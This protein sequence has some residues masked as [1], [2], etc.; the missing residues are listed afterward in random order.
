[1]T[2]ALTRHVAHRWLGSSH[3]SLSETVGHRKDSFISFPAVGDV[4]SHCLSA[5]HQAIMQPNHPPAQIL[6]LQ[7]CGSHQTPP[8][9][10]PDVL[11]VGVRPVEGSQKDE[12]R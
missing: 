7:G 1:M 2:C 11:D 10:D 4:S 6:T 3:E 8:F 5:A 9:T 12:M